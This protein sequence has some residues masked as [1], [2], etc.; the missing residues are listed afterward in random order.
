MAGD[1]SINSKQLRKELE[2]KS[3]HPI[4]LFLGEEEGEKDK[5][6]DM[7]IDLVHDGD[8][9]RNNSVRRFSMEGNDGITP[10]AAHALSGSLFSAKATCV[11]KN[12]HNLKPTKENKA[13]ARELVSQLPDTSTLIMTAEKYQAPPL[14]GAGELNRIKVVKF[15]K[16]YENETADYIREGFR[17]AGMSIDPKA[18]EQLME[19]TGRDMRKIDEAIEGIRY[20]GSGKAVTA[21][22]IASSLGDTVNA[23]LFDFVHLLFRLETGSLKILGQVLDEGIPELVILSNMTKEAEAIEKY[24]ALLSGGTA[25]D[26]A[27]KKCG[28]FSKHMES[29][30]KSIR[31]FTPEKITRLF[32]MLSRADMEIKSGG[33]KKSILSNPVFILASEILVG[34]K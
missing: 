13:V 23:D 22:I 9:D 27:L 2:K 21:E 17:K 30:K 16:L 32:P 10:A 24:H 34:F 14:F 29:F 20:S 33:M 3:V 31:I 18:L 12:I 7:I 28:V 8:A 19:L 26:E 25:Q 15:W 1:N 4:Y 11:I 6:I 5:L